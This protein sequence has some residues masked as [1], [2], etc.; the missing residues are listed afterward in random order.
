[1]REIKLVLLCFFLISNLNAFEVYK[2]NNN[3]G[4]Y[5]EVDDRYKIEQGP[6]WYQDRNLSKKKP[7]QQPNATFENQQQDAIPKIDTNQAILTKLSELVEI[8][9][10]QLDLQRKTFLLLQEEFN[11][12]PHT[13]INEK[14]EKCVANSSADCFEMPLVAEAKRVPVLATWI[15]EPTIENA[16]EFL[17]WQAKFFKYKFDNGYSLNLASKQYGDKAYPTDAITEEFGSIGGESTRHKNELIKTYITAKSK[18]TSVY[19][20]M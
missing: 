6:M 10:M 14:G 18:N 12:Q 17:K 15:K 13:I 8:Q 19:I 5:N 3:S 16:T 7:F 2:D 4:T 11:P 9:K 1:M 20:L